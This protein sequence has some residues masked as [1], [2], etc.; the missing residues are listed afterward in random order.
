MKIKDKVWVVTGGGSGMGRE[1]VLQ[2]LARGGR[3]A[4]ADINEAG[5]QETAQLAGN[6]GARLSIHTLNIADKEQ[7]LAFPEQVLA[8]HGAVDGLINNAGIIQPFIKVNDLEFAA[9]EK[10]MNVNFYGT[11]YMVKAFLPH[12]LERPEAHI[13]NISSMGGFLPVPGQTFYGASKAAVKLLTEGLHSEL[14]D[15]PVKVTVIFPGAVNTNISVNSGLQAPA[16]RQAEDSPIQP[17]DAGKAA[18]I[19][20]DGIEKDKYRVLVGKDA[21]FMDAY[22]RLSPKGAARLIYKKMKELLS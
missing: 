2:L 14:I 22:S 8:A 5:M 20:L 12:L 16:E 1:L 11:L 17:L 10:V 15:S 21:R 18:E 3:V 7:V 4:V 13:A 6:V 19:M 9:I